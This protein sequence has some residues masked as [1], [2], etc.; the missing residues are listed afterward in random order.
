MKHFM[1]GAIINL[2]YKVR[3]Q[4]TGKWLVLIEH[5]VRNAMLTV[6]AEEGTRYRSEPHFNRPK[7]VIYCCRK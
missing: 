7:F 6:M 1:C 2:M 4:R 5:A 3:P